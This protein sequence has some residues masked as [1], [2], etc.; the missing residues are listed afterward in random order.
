MNKTNGKF[1]GPVLLH[2]ALVQ[3]PFIKGM[4]EFIQLSDE[5]GGRP[6]LQF[7]NKELTVEENLQILKGVAVSPHAEGHRAPRDSGPHRR[8]AALLPRA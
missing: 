6:I 3:E 4:R 1:A 5:F 7:E 8:R 2:T